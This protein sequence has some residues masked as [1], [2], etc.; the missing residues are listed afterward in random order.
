MISIREPKIKI[1]LRCGVCCVQHTERQRELWSRELSGVELRGED[2]ERKRRW[3]WRRERRGL[4]VQQ[5]QQPELC[6]QIILQ[7]VQAAPPPR[8]YQNP[9]WFQVASSYWRL[10][11]HRLAPTTPLS[12]FSVSSKKKKKKS[13]FFYFP[14]SFPHFLYNNCF[15]CSWS[16]GCF[17]VALKN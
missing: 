10:D 6:F 1:C 14:H 13:L 3:R 2:V 16:C 8:R 15:L 11:L 12:L 5:L 17:F 9:R 4:G 7:S